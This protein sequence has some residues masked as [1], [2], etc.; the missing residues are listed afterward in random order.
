MINRQARQKGVTLLELLIAMAI[1]WCFHMV[2]IA[3][4]GEIYFIESNP[5]VL[6]GEIA[7]TVLITLFAV[8]VFAYQCKRLPSSSAVMPVHLPVP[9]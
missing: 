6:Y 2:L 5:V 7:A 1:A 9:F 3:R 4:H 8:T